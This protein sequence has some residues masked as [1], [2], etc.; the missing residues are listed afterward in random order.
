MHRYLWSELMPSINAKYF[1]VASDTVELCLRI[2]WTDER[3]L[4]E[5]SLRLKS[6]KRELRIP[7]DYSIRKLGKH[8]DLLILLR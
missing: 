4:L 8:Q 6:Q 3:A 5:G 2:Y 7:P 1:F